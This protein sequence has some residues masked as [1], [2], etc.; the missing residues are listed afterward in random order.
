MQNINSLPRESF[1]RSPFGI[2]TLSFKNRFLLGLPKNIRLLFGG[3]T[4]GFVLVAVMYFIQ[5]SILVQHQTQLKNIQSA[6][7]QLNDQTLMLVAP[8]SGA[9]QMDEVLSALERTISVAKIATASSLNTEIAALNQTFIDAAIAQE[10]LHNAELTI[11]DR[12]LN[13]LANAKQLAAD[14]P[15]QALAVSHLLNFMA[16]NPVP[17]HDRFNK[18]FLDF[19]QQFSHAQA[20]MTNDDAHVRFV[21]LVQEVDSWLEIRQQQ[22]HLNE[23]LATLKNNAFSTLANTNAAIA[24]KYAQ[25]RATEANQ[26]VFLMV[27]FVLLLLGVFMGVALAI[28]QFYR[29]AGQRVTQIKNVLKRINNGKLKTRIEGVEDDGLG[30]LSAELNC[31]LDKHFELLEA[32]STENEQLNNSIITLIRAVGI[33]ARKDLTV[34]VPVSVDITGSISDAINLLTSETGRTLA[35]VNNI[36]QEVDR[37]ADVL[38]GKSQTVLNLAEQER[39]EV[40]ATVKALE[41]STLAMNEIASK[42]GVADVLA[43]AAIANTRQARVSVEQSFTR[44]LTIKSTMAETEKRIK[45]LGDRSQEVS[46]IVNLINTIAERTHI[47]ALNAS[48]HA[49]SAGEAGKGFALVAAE[50]QRLAENVREATADIASMVHN[51]RIETSDAVVIMNRLIMEVA[52]GTKIAEMAGQHMNDT[53]VATHELVSLVSVMGE[54]AI[55]QAAVTQNV[56]DRANVIRDYTQ[57][58]G[59]QLLDQN[60]LT[61]NLKV[62]SEALVEQVGLFKLPDT[63]IS[64]PTL[65]A[66]VS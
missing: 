52:E 50:V 16:R 49:A 22:Q 3:L 57:K 27:M 11:N 59:A 29:D 14:F 21:Q 33:I 2:S 56:R 32:Q 54:S 62:Q 47:L 24:T 61:S 43:K 4:L 44:I 55:R 15:A 12:A 8:I 5:A 20:G 41:H 60:S 66:K 31:F 7:Q 25:L 51:I 18:E 19:K 35:L 58:T 17:S 23:N 37:V 64:V 34:K 10:T 53:D 1:P 36:S 65:V 30:K 46:G 48:M 26:F 45:R 63:K 39:I 42:A 38:H 6:Q 40:M 28:Y 13:I 9:Q